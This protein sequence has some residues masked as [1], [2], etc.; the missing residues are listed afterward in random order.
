MYGPLHGAKNWQ[1]RAITKHP[2]AP[3]WPSE[4]VSL[5]LLHARKG[6]DNRACYR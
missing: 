4:V 1:L 6:V 2:D 3:L 5:G